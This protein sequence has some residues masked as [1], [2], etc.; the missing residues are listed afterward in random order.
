MGARFNDLQTGG[1]VDQATY[2]D[3]F[4]SVE[5]GRVVITLDGDGFNLFRTSVQVFKMF[6]AEM[7]G[8]LTRTQ[9]TEFWEEFGDSVAANKP[10]AGD[11]FTKFD[12]NRNNQ[13]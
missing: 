9:F 2:I 7:N 5:E 12:R 6:D 8:S 1:V 11:P 10:I 4:D 13:V 3:W